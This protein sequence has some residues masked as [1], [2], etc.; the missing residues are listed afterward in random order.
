MNN[1][2]KVTITDDD[3]EMYEMNETNKLDQG[4]H[5]LIN[6][7]ISSLDDEIA[8]INSRLSPSKSDIEPSSPT[9]QRPAMMSPTAGHRDFRMKWISTVK[10]QYKHLGEDEDF[11]K[12]PVHVIDP[13]LFVV[14]WNPFAAPPTKDEK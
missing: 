4:K 12:P 8:L 5:L 7:N 3:G 1:D 9:G 6:S 14:G 11:L 13:S 2:S 10:T